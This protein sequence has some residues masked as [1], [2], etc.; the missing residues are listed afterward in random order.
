MRK[1][2]P[3]FDPDSAEASL[4]TNHRLFP[5]VRRNMAAFCP[6]A[7]ASTNTSID[8]VE[9]NIIGSVAPVTWMPF[10]SVIVTPLFCS[11]P[12]VPSKRATVLSV[13]A[14]GTAEPLPV[15]LPTTTRSGIASL[16]TSDSSTMSPAA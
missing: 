6:G 3:A 9:R 14:P 2:L 10:P 16:P 8:A 12:P 5:A 15:N 7:P 4:P 1:L 11:A 13:D